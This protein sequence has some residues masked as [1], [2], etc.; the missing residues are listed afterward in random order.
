MLTVQT[1]SETPP[2]GWKVHV[3][4]TNH[5]VSHYAFDAF[6]K[7]Y[8]SHLLANN[9]PLLPNYQETLV[10]R[11]CRENPNWDCKQAG[12]FKAI[13][14]GN[15]FGPIMS[16]LR[17]AL[18]WAKESA[19]DGKP[20]WESQEVA[21][22]RANICATCPYN[23]RKILF[24]CGGC[25]SLF[26][27]TMALILGKSLHVSGEDRIGACRLCQC[28]LKVAV[29]MPLKVQQDAL[30]ERTKELFREPEVQKFCWKS[31]GL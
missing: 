29:H 16:F 20:A 21:Q 6:I 2:G 7:A 24:S 8:E 4:E 25:G 22:A 18:N 13:G 3:H 27:K 1:F 10:D 19:I 30:D 17:F 15:L 12:K 9:I 26:I 31:S 11:M 5:T 14:K 23:T 28:T